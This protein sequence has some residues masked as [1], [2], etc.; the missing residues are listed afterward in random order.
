MATPDSSSFFYNSMLAKSLVQLLPSHEKRPLRDWFT[1]L[2][3]LVNTPKE[4]ELRDEYIWFIL[5]MLQCQKI[6]EPFDN[7]PPAQ[8]GDLRDIV[9]AK[10][11]EE[12]LVA[13]SEN[14]TWVDKVGAEQKPAGAEGAAGAGPNEEQERKQWCAPGTFLENQPLP[15]EGIICYMSTFS[16]QS[17]P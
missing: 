14:M 3:E 13:N 2:N 12:I 16:D 1:K 10:V 17:Y 9:P 4:L 8:I 6:R 7:P 5:M 11:Y 15:Q